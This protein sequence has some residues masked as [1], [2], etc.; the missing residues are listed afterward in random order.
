MHC[1]HSAETGHRYKVFFGPDVVRF[2]RAAKNTCV[3]GSDAD[4]GVLAGIFQLRAASP[5]GAPKY[6]RMSQDASPVLQVGAGAR[7]LKFQ[8]LAHT[9]TFPSMIIGFEHNE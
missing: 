7:V 6:L 4:V 8:N 5:F 2:D 3:I 9:Y 1:L